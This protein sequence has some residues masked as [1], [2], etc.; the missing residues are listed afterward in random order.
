MGREVRRTQETSLITA[1]PK[2]KA[3]K[4]GGRALYASSVFPGPGGISTWFVGQASTQYPCSLAIS[5]HKHL[6]TTDQHHC[7]RGASPGIPSIWEA[8]DPEAGVL[9]THVEFKSLSSGL[10]LW[11]KR[12][13]EAFLEGQANF[14][15]PACNGEG[16]VPLVFH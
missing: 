14:S 12:Q 4:E 3:R 11:I 7:P 2:V 15:F 10:N 8:L 6:P 16:V 9:R 5:P 13:M 1:Y